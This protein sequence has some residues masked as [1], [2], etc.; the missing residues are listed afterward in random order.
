MTENGF[1]IGWPGLAANTSPIGVFTFCSH[2]NV[3]PLHYVKMQRKG[4]LYRVVFIPVAELQGQSTIM[5]L[6]QRVQAELSVVEEHVAHNLFL[7]LSGTVKK[8]EYPAGVRPIILSAESQAKLWAIIED[9]RT[10]NVLK[11]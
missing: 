3:L 5:W 7:I 9:Q 4:S 10:H 8:A 1:I 2:P 11:S 6:Q